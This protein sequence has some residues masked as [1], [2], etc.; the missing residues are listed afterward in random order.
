MFLK[1]IMMV[2]VAGS[3]KSTVA[4]E[5][6]ESLDNC[7]VV[8]SD[9]IRGELYGD[10][11]IQ[12]DFSCVF[13]LMEERTMEALRAGRNVIY[14]ATNV[15]AWRRQEFLAKLPLEVEKICLWVNVPVERALQNNRM[16]ERHVPEWVI[17]HQAEQLEFPMSDEGWD[18]I[19]VITY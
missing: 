14:D 12:G 19:Y 6:V 13:Q 16:R 17:R 11:A 8:S 9:T 5:V 18:A 2:G 4:S 10:E 15:I 7:L 3:G 1:F